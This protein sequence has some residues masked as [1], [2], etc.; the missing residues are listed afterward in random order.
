MTP[1][2]TRD[3]TRR[4]APGA[5][6]FDFDGLVL[7][8]ESCTYV[9]VQA[10]FAEHGVALDRSFWQTILGTSNHPHWTEI[11][12]GRL[13][14]PVDRAA[15]VA[16]REQE[17][18][19]LLADEPVCE[20]VVD[21]LDAAS[22][23]GVPTAVASSSS[24]EWVVG[25]LERLR[26]RDRFAAV[27]TSDDVGRDP[28]RSKPAPDI[29]LAAAEAL[30]VA[31]ADCVVLED[32][33]NGVAAGRAAGMAVVAVPGPMTAGLDFG[34]AHLEVSTIAHLDLAGL[35]VLVGRAQGAGAPRH[36][37]RRTW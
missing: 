2:V 10:I 4:D 1:A 9:T 3:R 17:R 23:A 31:P 12:A 21:L 30:G 33:L 7:D 15:L 16:R 22:A 29:F 11:L 19:R 18:L 35:A 24:A 13:G 5:V 14:R 37:L 36:A 34:A 20:G 6:L 27:V 8:T 32:S 26:L 25:H 28:R